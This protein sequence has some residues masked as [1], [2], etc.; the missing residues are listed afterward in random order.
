MPALFDFDVQGLTVSPDGA[1]NPNNHQVPHSEAGISVSCAVINVGDEP[2][3]ARVG[4]EADGTFITEWTSGD[5]APGGS[6]GPWGVSLGRYS[7]G[8]HTFLA[9]VNPG[10]GDASKDHASNTVNLD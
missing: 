10:S 7:P 1:D 6:D 8:Q 3:S 5:V 9:Y 4:F 2:G